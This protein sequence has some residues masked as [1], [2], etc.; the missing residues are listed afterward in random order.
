M[1]VAAVYPLQGSKMH[2]LPTPRGSLEWE[3]HKE[4]IFP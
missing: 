1:Q 2:L 3:K 4:L